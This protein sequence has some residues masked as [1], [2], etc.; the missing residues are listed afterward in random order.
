VSVLEQ[1]R[2]FWD[3]DAATYDLDPGHHP[4]GVLQRAAWRDALEDLLPPAPARVLDVGAGTGF[5]TLL[6]AEL[7]HEMTAVDISPRMLARLRQKAAAEQLAVN[8]IEADAVAVPA[9]PFDAVVSRHLLWTLVDPVAALTAWR[10]ASPAGLLILIDRD[11]A[12][13]SAAVAV[14]R[15]SRRALDRLR[16]TPP[17]HHGTYAPEVARALPLFGGSGPADLLSLVLQAGWASPRI[18]RLPDLD[19]AMQYGQPWTDRLTSV[20]PHFAIVATASPR[21]LDG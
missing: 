20:A 1:I 2:D 16:P 17:T 15:L 6:A 4:Q 13:E 18:R 19:W 10:A 3:A 11:W 8:A 12:A 9:G 5:I 7:S 21:H 14:R